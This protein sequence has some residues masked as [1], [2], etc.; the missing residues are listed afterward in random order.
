MKAG[1][2]ASASIP[3]IF[4]FVTHKEKTLVDGGCLYPITIFDAVNRC[5]EAGFDDKDIIVDVL[6]ASGAKLKELDV[7]NYN[8]I[9]MLIRY[10]RNKYFTI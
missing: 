4:P 5:R 10:V 8:A 1:I 7:S 2:L 3:G 6:E 9:Q